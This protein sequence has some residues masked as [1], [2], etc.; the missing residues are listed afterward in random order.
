[1]RGKVD[2]TGT[3]SVA[4]AVVAAGPVTGNDEIALVAD[5]SN[6]KAGVRGSLV[7][8]RVVGVLAARWHFVF[9]CGGNRYTNRGTGEK[10]GLSMLCLIHSRM[11]GEYETG[12]PL[13]PRLG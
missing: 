6:G 1:M 4:A 2:A 8:G 9:V 12:H 5:R 11:L 10:S 7:N 3:L 13:I